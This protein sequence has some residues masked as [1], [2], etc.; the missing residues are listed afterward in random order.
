MRTD[1]ETSHIV[2]S[3]SGPPHQIPWSGSL[4]PD[5]RTV[6]TWS[7]EEQAK[8]QAERRAEVVRLWDHYTRPMDDECCAGRYLRARG[9]GAFVGCTSLRQSNF[10]PMLVSRVWHVQHGLSAV[11]MTWLEWD[12]HDRDRTQD[13]KTKGVLK[14]AAV[15][16]GQVRAD[17]EV[18]VAEGL[19]SLLSAL[20]L[21][22]LRCGAAALGPNL[23]GLVL[24]RSVRKIHIAADNDE[25]G[26]GSA[27]CAA[28][29]WRSRGLCVRESY[30][31]R[32]GEDF[33]DVLK[34]ELRL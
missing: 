17:E 9:L 5:A 8:F 20:L 18:V 23:K 25:T 4:E 30:P 33:N 11:Q 32:E 2:T 34:L 26:R 21:M 15:W 29:L 16:I 22:D 27:S 24:P 13:R 12:G 6:S 14:G 28:E 7:K 31:V 3:F 10:F 19:E 1:H